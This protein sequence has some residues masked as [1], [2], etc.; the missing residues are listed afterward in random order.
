VC[1]AFPRAIRRSGAVW[2]GWC[3]TFALHRTGCSAAAMSLPA[4]G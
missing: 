1:H 2:D 4:Q 3:F